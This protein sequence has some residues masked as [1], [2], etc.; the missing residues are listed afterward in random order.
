PKTDGIFGTQWL[1][2]IDFAP[3]NNAYTHV[4]PPNANSCT[5]APDAAQ[6]ISN[7]TWGGI[8]AAVTATS[9]HPGGINVAFCDGSV[10]FIK[11]SIDLQTW[12]ALGTR[13]G[14]EVISG[15]AY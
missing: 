3:A 2:S 9:N 10:K 14:K 7:P 6:V 5:G 15:D 4:M 12:W 13:D 8:G 11:D 1:P